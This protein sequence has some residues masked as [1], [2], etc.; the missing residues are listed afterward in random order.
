MKIGAGIRG[1]EVYEAANAQNV[2]VMGGDCPSVGLAGGF[3]QG[4]GHSCLSSLYGMGADQVL[5]W[6]V[7]T[8]QGQH[9]IAT[10]KQNS[11][12]YWALSGG[13]PGT[14]GVVISLTVRTHPPGLVGGA[15]L[16]FASAGISNDT[17]WDA[18]AYWQSLQE[19]LVDAGTSSIAV[20]FASGFQLAPLTAPGASVNQTTQLLA[21]F[22][23]YLTA[24]NISFSLSVT[25]LPFLE[26]YEKYL[27][28]FPFGSQP[29]AQL[30]GGRLIP[31]S[32]V[33]NNNT[34]LTSAFRNII[35]DSTFYLAII[36]LNAGHPTRESP[37]APN[38][39]LPAWRDAL[40]TVIV[41]SPWDFRG[42]RSVEVERAN[43]L[44][45][46]LEPSLEALTPT[47]G[48]YMNEA[49]FQDP[50]WKQNFYGSNY[51]ALRAIKAKY[52]HDDLFYAATAVGSDA[53]SAAPDGRLCRTNST[54]QG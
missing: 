29:T 35:E 23:K 2:V 33:K 41:I 53:W 9:L 34:A 1:F 37:V 20:V 8:A 49:N 39:V 36:S 14:Y 16:G 44:T 40:F 48:T 26:H 25:S 3:T 15:S 24:H 18:I 50:N 10:P 6:E 31:R 4:G 38:A 54:V 13:G 19:R 7:V 27:G 30:T 28:P 21:P 17:Y 43:L 47:S 12:L 52:D 42:P 45:N 5:E 11:D 51:G 22:T 32:V 46:V